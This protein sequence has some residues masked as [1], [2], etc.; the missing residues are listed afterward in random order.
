MLGVILFCPAFPYIFPT[1][2]PSNHQTPPFPSIFQIDIHRKEVLQLVNASSFTQRTRNQLWV[3]F[4]TWSF[5]F[6]PKVSDPVSCNNL[7]A[8]A[9]SRVSL[10]LSLLLSLLFPP[11]LFL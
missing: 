1:P 7:C 3:G 11:P 2:T 8:L 6:W 10:F 4:F 5:R 9:L